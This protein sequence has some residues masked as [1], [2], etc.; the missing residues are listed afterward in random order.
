MAN[1]SL[2][3]LTAQ[4]VSK[5]ED[6]LKVKCVCGCGPAA[7]PER[8]PI[9]GRDFTANVVRCSGD[10]PENMLILH[11]K[12]GDLEKALDAEMKKK[13]LEDATVTDLVEF[14][15]RVFGK[16]FADCVAEK[17]SESED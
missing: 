14:G 13:L 16:D 10:T 7:T 9:H 15:F 12:I 6:A 5:L 11:A 8:C 2:I 17:L 1:G 3:V 4:D